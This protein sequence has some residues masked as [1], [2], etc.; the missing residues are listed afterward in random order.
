ML[1]IIERWVSREL[2]NVTDQ[3]L[4]VGNLECDI[5][6]RSVTKDQ[7]H[8]FDCLH[9]HLLIFG[10]EILED[11]VE[12]LYPAL[13]V[14]VADKPF[15]AIENQDLASALNDLWVISLNVAVY[16][17]DYAVALLFKLLQHD[18]RIV[19]TENHN[20]LES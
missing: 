11:G 6:N 19:L 10:G 9:S 15:E 7:R 20:L 17:V 4:E 3:E 5:V 2:L 1:F 8:Q 16:A 14:D 18:F 12:E 13:P